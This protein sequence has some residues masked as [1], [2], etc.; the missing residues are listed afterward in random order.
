MNI[1][2]KESKQ[3]GKPGLGC[4]RCGII[5]P[6]G[7]MV[8]REGKYYCIHHNPRYTKFQLDEMDAKYPDREPLGATFG[9]KGGPLQ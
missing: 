1:N 3:I 2:P 6:R 9:G 5:Y 7:E 4:C 8:K